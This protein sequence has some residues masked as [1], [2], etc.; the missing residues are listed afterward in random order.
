MANYMVY[1]TKIMNITQCYTGTFSHSAN[2]T[3]NPK[4]YPIDEACE[5][6]GRSY[7]YCPCDEMEVVRIYGVSN[8][9]TN[10]IWLT[11]TSKVDMPVITDYVTMMVIHPEDDDLKKLK[12]GQKF[13]RGEPMFREGKDGN[14]TGNHF[15]IS[16]GLGKLYLNGW[17]ENDKKAWVIRSSGGSL[18]PESA[19]YL[20]PNIT[21]VRNSQGIKFK[22]VPSST[23][24]STVTKGIDV[25]KYQGIIDWNKVKADGISFVMV[26]AGF[27]NVKSQI[28]PKFVANVEGA[29]SVGLHVGAYWFSY[30]YNTNMVKQEAELF[31]SVLE[32]YKGKIDFP[33]V[34]DFEYDSVNYAKKNGVNIAKK[35]ATEFASLFCKEMEKYG[36]YSMNYTNLDY[37]NNYFDQSIMKSIDTWYANWSVNKPN[38]NCG[39]WQYSNKGKVNGISGD[40]DLDYSYKDYPKIIKNAKLNGFGDST[41]IKDDIITEEHDCKYKGMYEEE[42]KKNEELRLENQN[43]YIEN[44]NLSKSLESLSD[45]IQQLR[46]GIDRLFAGI[47][48]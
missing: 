35:I 46:D 11:S 38:I 13:K 20:D 44:S 16:F 36:W 22:T 27:G 26:R 9:G 24:D 15:H 12:V 7:I 32:P 14:A 33:V 48:S 31:K 37:Y 4:D 1:P 34:Y 21:T 47:D 6:S 45:K 2:N 28:D 30:A 29:L 41:D 3:G 42:M 17:M 39:I 23:I 5:N 43:L 40:V 19:C 25:S 8:N 18:K 10:T